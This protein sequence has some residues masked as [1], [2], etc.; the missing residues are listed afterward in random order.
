LPHN[1]PSLILNLERVV[2]RGLVDILIS[3]GYPGRCQEVHEMVLAKF[4]DRIKA[5]SKVSLRL[6][7]VFKEE[8]ISSD[9]ELQRP[10][11]TTAFDPSGME[12]IG[13]EPVLRQQADRVLCTTEMGL[14]RVVRQTKENQSWL[15]STLLLKP[16]V[17]LESVADSMSRHYAV[18]PVV[19]IAA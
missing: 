19:T 10:Q 3:G 8:I 7:Q 11:P 12:D 16:K 18:E 2:V 15:D 1:D 5:I 9:L 4:C 6:N 17:A 13:G 14:R